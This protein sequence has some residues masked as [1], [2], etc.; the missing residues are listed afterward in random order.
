MKRH[1][2]DLLVFPKETKKRTL[3]LFLPESVQNK[4]LFI[5]YRLEHEGEIASVTDRVA[6]LK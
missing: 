2:S 3:E 5:D 4:V 1:V 6:L